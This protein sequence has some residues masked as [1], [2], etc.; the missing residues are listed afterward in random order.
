MIDI[1]KFNF[2]IDRDEKIKG[3]TGRISHGAFLQ[4]IRKYDIELSAELHEGNKRRPYSLWPIKFD[5]DGKNGELKIATYDKKLSMNLFSIIGN[6]QDHYIVLV[7]T[8]CPIY[9]VDFNR[10]NVEKGINITSNNN[11]QI[12]T[13]INKG[14][15]FWINFITPTI[16]ANDS[17]ISKIDPYP[18]LDRIWKNLLDTYEFLVKKLDDKIKILEQLNSSIAVSRFKIRSI[19]VSMSNYMKFPAFKGSIKFVVEKNEK[20]YILPT[21]LNIAKYWGI[22]GKRSMGLGKVRIN[23]IPFKQDS[24]LTSD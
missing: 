9:Q 14:D 5:Q 23:Y 10:V 11:S 21:L 12:I 22:G 18:N 16:F 20:L 4:Y 17:R 2:I 7:D 6:T 19:S 8:K 13:N 24:Q 3:F 15:Q 1:F